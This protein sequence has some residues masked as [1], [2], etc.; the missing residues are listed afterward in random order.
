MPA[1]LHVTEAL[2]AK[3]F[4]NSALEELAP[5]GAENE[6]RL[7][8]KSHAFLKDKPTRFGNHVA[9]VAGNHTGR[10]SGSCRSTTLRNRTS[11]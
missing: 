2:L 11:E 3:L 1:A 7:N 9:A 4:E 6:G 8:T 5:S 10:R